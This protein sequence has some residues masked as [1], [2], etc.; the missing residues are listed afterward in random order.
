MLRIFPGRYYFAQN[1]VDELDTLVDEQ[2]F[3]VKDRD[4]AVDDRI[5]KGNALY[6]KLVELAEYGKSAWL[7]KNEAKYNDYVI[8]EVQKKAAQ[9][10]EG[11]ISSGQIINLSATDVQAVTQLTG[12]A[13]GNGL[14]IYFSTNPTDYPNGFQQAVNEGVENS[15]IAGAIGFDPGNRERLMLYNP[16][17]NNATYKVVVEA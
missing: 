13:T 7:N 10:L 11:N 16:G 3:A 15:F 1:L 17:P 9:V 8:T 4:I 2:R 12:E 14:Q 6:E 5:K